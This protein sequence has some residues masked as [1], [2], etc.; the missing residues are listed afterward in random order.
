MNKK[1]IKQCIRVAR[2]E[3]NEKLLYE[4]DFTEKQQKVMV[5]FFDK[6][7][8]DLRKELTC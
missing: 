7:F 4:H 8:K 3:I 1:E 5:D 2:I 6:L